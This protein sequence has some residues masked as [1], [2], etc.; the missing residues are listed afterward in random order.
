VNGHSFTAGTGDRVY[1]A[2][3]AGFRE[4]STDTLLD[5][6]APNGTTVLEADDND[7]TT[8]SRSNTGDTIAVIVD[9]GPERAT[10]QWNVIDGIGV[11]CGSFIINC[12]GSGRRRGLQIH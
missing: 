7:V 11:F 8:E 6:I 2:T 4:G 3:L 12:S 5:I 10:P 9:T 1:A